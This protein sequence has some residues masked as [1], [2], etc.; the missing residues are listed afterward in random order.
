[1]AIK[2]TL[3]NTPAVPA[4]YETADVAAIQALVRGEAT[5]DQQQRALKWVIECGAGAYGFHYYESERDT[6][7]A[8]GRAFVGQ[9]VIK[10]TRLNLHSLRRNENG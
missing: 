10:L 6:A 2:K 1:M 9:Q 5:P 7:F 8:L 3:A 4:S